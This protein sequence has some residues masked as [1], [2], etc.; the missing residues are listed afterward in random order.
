MRV[1]SRK[2][3]EIHKEGNTDH[4]NGPTYDSDGKQC[5]GLSKDDIVWIAAAAGFC[6][7]SLRD[8]PNVKVARYYSS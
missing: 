7:S 3:G 2:Y 6:K 8:G 1:S 5:G 4:Q